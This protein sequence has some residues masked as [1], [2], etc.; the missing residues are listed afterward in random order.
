MARKK[1]DFVL[2]LTVI[3][4]VD[5]AQVVRELEAADQAMVHGATRKGGDEVML[6]R[7]GR[8]LTDVVEANQLN[9]LHAED[10]QQLLAH[11]AEL[12][13]NAPSLHISF[14]ADP[15][16]V[17]M[18][19]LTVWIRHEIHPH[20]LIRTGLLPSIGAG[21]VLRTTNQVFDFS[22]KTQFEK[23]RQ[24]LVDELRASAGQPAAPAA[25]EAA[26]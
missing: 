20:A 4:P 14:N 1:L 24:I 17:F 12:K 6:P 11:L 19:K 9:L 21:C 7:Q 18:Q 23:S 26:A 5:L 8:L 3:T 10:R 25:T 15:S 16:P 13:D 22:L 2:P